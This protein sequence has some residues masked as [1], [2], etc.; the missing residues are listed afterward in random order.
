MTSQLS[1]KIAF[2]LRKRGVTNFA[3]IIKFTA[4]IIKKWLKTQKKLKQLEITY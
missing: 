4:M 1:F 3:D 2:I